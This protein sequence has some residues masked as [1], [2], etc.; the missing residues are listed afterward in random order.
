MSKNKRSISVINLEASSSDSLTSQNSK[1]VRLT[2]SNHAQ[3]CDDS[4]CKGC[5]VGEVEIVFTNEEGQEVELSPN[6]LLQL[7]LEES[8]KEPLREHGIAKRLFDMSLEGFDKLITLEEQKI[9]VETVKSKE[10]EVRYRFATKKTRYQYACCCVAFGI[11][12]PIIEHLR[13]GIEIYKQIIIEDDGYYDAWIG[14]GRARI[15]LAKIEREM[16]RND[17]NDL[18]DSE[19]SKE[20]QESSIEIEQASFNMAIDAFDKGLSILKSKDEKKYVI[21]SILIAKDLQEYVMSIDHLKF[22]AYTQKIFTKVINYLQDIYDLDNI[23]LNEIN[24]AQGIHGCCLYY[25]AKLKTDHNDDENE[26]SKMFLNEAIEKLLKANDPLEE[27]RFREILGQAYIL[28]T[29]IESDEEQIMEAYEKGRECLK[30]AYKF[31]PDNENLREQL[32]T[33]GALSNDDDEEY[34]DDDD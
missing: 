3:T 13:K 33:L 22:T 23:Y 34:L 19:N 27:D 21:K 5:D 24:F 29:I 11:Y 16:S 12:L 25:L 2:P 4:A 26:E 30:Q 8:S 7:A 20:E 10:K 28:K 1:K 15:H 18:S 17:Q 31:D 6:E 32:E 14:L 9:E